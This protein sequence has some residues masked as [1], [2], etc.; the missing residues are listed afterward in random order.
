MFQTSVSPDDLSRL[1]AV[2]SRLQSVPMDPIHSIKR[3]IHKENEDKRDKGHS[4][5]QYLNL[6]CK[7]RTK[8]EPKD[9]VDNYQEMKQR[10]LEVKGKNCK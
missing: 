6:E 10:A 9:P 1:S 7:V 5:L 2:M 4:H 8:M 3:W